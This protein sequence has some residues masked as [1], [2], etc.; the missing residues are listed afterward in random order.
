[1]YSSASAA[2]IKAMLMRTVVRYGSHYILGTCR[3][4]CVEFHARKRQYAI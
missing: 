2:K 1:L 3:G 4:D